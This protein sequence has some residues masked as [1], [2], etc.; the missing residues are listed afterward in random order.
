LTGG[1]PASHACKGRKLH[2]WDLVFAC[3]PLPTVGTACLP[4]GREFE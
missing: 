1:C 4:V 3:L 2:N